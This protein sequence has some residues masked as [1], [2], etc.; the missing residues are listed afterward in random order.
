LALH[1]CSLPPHDWRKYNGNER[2]HKKLI[3]SMT[4]HMGPKGPKG[5]KGPTAYMSELHILEGMGI[6]QTV[7]KV[8]IVS[9]KMAWRL[10]GV[11]VETRPPKSLVYYLDVIDHSSHKSILHIDECLLYYA[12]EV[13]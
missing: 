11:F 5:H 4:F 8:V 2:R 1:P 9:L 7:F 10:C 12:K 13:K 3:M 6:G